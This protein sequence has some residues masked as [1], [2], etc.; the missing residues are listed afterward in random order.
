MCTRLHA[1]FSRRCGRSF[2]WWQPRASTEVRLRQEAKRES[3]PASEMR[4]QWRRSRDARDGAQERER[5]A[6][7]VIPQRCRERRRSSAPLEATKHAMASSSTPLQPP[8]SR[9]ESRRSPLSA[10]VAAPAQEIPARE[11]TRRRCAAASSDQSPRPATPWQCASRSSA[12]DGSPRASPRTPA[13]VTLEQPERLTE[14]SAGRRER[15]ARA[16]SV[17]SVHQAR[18]MDSRRGSWGAVAQTAASVSFTQAARL[19]D[20][21]RVSVPMAER[22]PP[23]SS[24]GQKLRSRCWREVR[25]GSASATAASSSEVHLARLSVRSTVNDSRQRGS[26]SRSQPPRSRLRSVPPR[27]AAS[28]VSSSPPSH[29]TCSQHRRSAR[30]RSC[31]ARGCE[32]AE[33][34]PGAVHCSQSLRSSSRSPERP[35]PPRIFDRTVSST[36]LQPLRSREAT[37]WPSPDSAERAS[38]ETAL[39]PARLRERRCLNPDRAPSS[40]GRMSPPA[41]CAALDRERPRAYGAAKSSAPELRGPG[42]QRLSWSLRCTFCQCRHTVRRAQASR[43]EQACRISVRT[44]SVRSAQGRE[45]PSS[46]SE[47]L[48]SSS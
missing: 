48:F 25:R 5:S 9:S 8:R 15:G 7:S 4:R 17:S 40:V 20:L 14:V 37:V 27:A 39:Q 16:S 34:S 31:G 29:P 2:S 41:A 12:S 13:P 43:R 10:S 42:G 11:S 30:V 21:S 32:R 24:V 1:A 3:T 6:S 44:D 36:P 26:A 28:G 38:A 33:A 45:E 46:G 18:E 23:G 22:A 35:R 19:R 47:L